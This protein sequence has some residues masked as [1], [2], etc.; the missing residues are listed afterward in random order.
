MS[1]RGCFVSASM[2]WLTTSS[3]VVMT[4]S[5]NTKASAME[6]LFGI[7]AICL[8]DFLAMAMVVVNL[9]RLASGAPDRIIS[10]IRTSYWGTIKLA[11]VLIFG[12]VLIRG[13][14]SAAGVPACGL[15][16]GVSTLVAVPLIGGLLWFACEKAV[17]KKCYGRA[18]I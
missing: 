11:C 16:L 10:V 12:A 3:A 7:A 17:G 9:L 4:L 5:G 13:R 1:A 18:S 15:L 2:L 8:M 14:S 6:W